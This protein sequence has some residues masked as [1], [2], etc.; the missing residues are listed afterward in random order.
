MS[1]SSRASRAFAVVAGLALALLTAA[2]G[3]QAAPEVGEPAPDFALPGTDGSVH[4]LSDS[5][6]R[7]GLVL[8]WF[9]KA[10]TPG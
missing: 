2:P 3:A 5:V 10:F 9:P 1:D 6:G 8:A 7:R 4:R